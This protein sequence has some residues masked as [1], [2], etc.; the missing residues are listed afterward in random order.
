MSKN[1]EFEPFAERCC[2][3]DVH[4]KEIVATVEGEG[5]ARETK[6]FESTT[7]SLT[8]LKE[9]LL[10]LDVTHVAME[11]TGVYWKPVMNVL[12]QGNFSIMVV[13][14]RHIKYVPGHKTDK[15]DSAWICKLLR[16]GLLKGS[17]VPSREQRNLR[18]LTRYRR[19]L[20]QQ[21]AAEHNRMIRVFEDANLK[22]SSV[23]SNIRGKTCTAVIDA[24][25]AG[26]TD[27]QKLAEMCTNRHLKST[28]EEIALAVEGN[29]TEHH[30]F[31]IRMIR[32]SIA[33]IERH[34]ADLDAE[35]DRRMAPVNDIIERLCGIPSMDRTSV[36]E[37][38]AEIG[39]DM[40]VFPTADHLASWAG[41][42]SGNNESAG[43]K[44]SSHTN[45]GN[46]ATKAIMSECA[47]CASRTKNTFFATRYK[48]L[49]AR[50][51]KKRAIVALGREILI[52]VY[53][54][55]KDGTEYR[56]LG[57]D[58]MD[59]RRKQAQIKYHKEQLKTL[60]GEDTPGQKKTA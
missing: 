31:M 53:H 39:V 54:M 20:V 37:L 13:N 10:E 6:T 59:D 9:W 34:I 40:E 38:I 43:K 4:K 28:Q 22:L 5:L 46:K 25:I 47:W 44:K 21:Q 35:I 49:S 50:R 3:L 16:A 1:V 29:F 11:S 14:A 60:L 41:M 18:D 42:S 7:R 32:D 12:E 57:P 52:I 23:F 30:M 8:E 48:R 36:K 51:G 45:H 15:K 24:V 19:K 26:E 55:L 27:P 58:Y 17:F 2:G 56:E 33:D